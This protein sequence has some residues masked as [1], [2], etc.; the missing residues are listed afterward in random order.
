MTVK[1]TWRYKIALALNQKQ[2]NKVSFSL[3]RLHLQLKKTY[4]EFNWVLECKLK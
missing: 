3:L 1:K 2:L 4:G